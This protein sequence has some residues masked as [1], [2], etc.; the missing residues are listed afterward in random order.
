M[1]RG[2]PAVTAQTRHSGRPRK[3]GTRV[4]PCAMPTPVDSRSNLHTASVYG[5]PLGVRCKACTRRGLVPLDKIGAHQGN[6]AELQ[7][8]PFK[9]SACGSREVELWLFVNRAEADDWAEALD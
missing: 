3:G 4:Y 7:S 2:E 9:C 8:L 1:E 6:M 5:Q